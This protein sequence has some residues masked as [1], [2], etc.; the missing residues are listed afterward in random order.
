LKKSFV[1]KFHSESNAKEK[2]KLED[3]F[4]TR[5]G[6]GAALVQEYQNIKQSLS[7]PRFLTEAYRKL[8]EGHQ[9]DDRELQKVLE[10]L[11][12]HFSEDQH[13]ILPSFYKLI[14]YLK[15]MKKDF[16]IL[17]R[18]FGSDIKDVANEFNQL[19]NQFR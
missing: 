10:K 7:L 3:E 6:L 12:Y 2:K 9:L 18:S 16:A 14:S 1:K 19:A 4:F 5:K 11:R 17:F 8:D 15:I 13:F